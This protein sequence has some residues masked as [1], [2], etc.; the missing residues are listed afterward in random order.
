MSTIRPRAFISEGKA[1][2]K[3]LMEMLLTPP[4]TPLELLRGGR[5]TD[6][7]TEPIIAPSGAKIADNFNVSVLSLA[8]VVNIGHNDLPYSQSLILMTPSLH[9]QLDRLSITLDF[10]QI[11]S[12][13]LSIT[14]AEGFV[15]WSK[16][17]RSVDIKDIPTTTATIKLLS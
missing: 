17:C 11:V 12:G 1:A 9:V 7:D 16:E 2:T 14:Q 15:G 3:L 4:R 13:R 5:N 8:T 10:N 6:S